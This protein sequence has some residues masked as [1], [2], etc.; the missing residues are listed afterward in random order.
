MKGIVPI[1]VIAAVCLSCSAGG[2]EDAVNNGLALHYRFDDITVGS[3]TVH[4]ASGNGHDGALHGQD[5]AGGVLGGAVYFEGYD[6]IVEIEDPGV[7]APATVALWIRT[8]D[9][10]HDRRILSPLEDPADRP[11]AIRLDGTRVDVWDGAAWQAVI[12][13]RTRI[14]TWMHVAV[15][16]AGDGRCYGYLNGERQHLVSCG[17]DFG[18]AEAGIGAA[19]PD[20]SGNPYTGL[21]DDFRI[22]DRAL[23]EDEIRALYRLADTP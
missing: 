20:G 1:I 12:D 15:V 9:L 21:M 13:R 8:S 18:G 4:D 16:F 19:F 23:G 5:T 17:F 11:G 2:P 7:T 14:N 22:Y 10:I 3:T 6:Q